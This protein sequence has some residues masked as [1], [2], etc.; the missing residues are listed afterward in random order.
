[1]CMYI[2]GLAVRTLCGGVESLLLFL[3]FCC[4]SV[5]ERF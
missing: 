4:V 5:S 1:V 2:V 3:L